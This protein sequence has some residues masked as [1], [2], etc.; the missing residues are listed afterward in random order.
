VIVT[1]FFYTQC[2][3]EKHSTYSPNAFV[4]C[5][6]Y[7]YIAFDARTTSI[8]ELMRQVQTPRYSKA[9]P[10]LKINVNIHNTYIPPTAH[11]NF[12]DGTEV[13]NDKCLLLYI[14]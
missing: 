5:Y 7:I 12:I 2:A 14:C 4:F 11:F 1:I 9:N 6:P 13:R 3:F 8:R 10:R